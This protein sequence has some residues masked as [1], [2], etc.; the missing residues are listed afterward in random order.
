MGV[1]VTPSL[2]TLGSIP[3]AHRPMKETY[4]DVVFSGQN[5]FLVWD[6]M[7][8]GAD[9]TNFYIVTS[10]VTPAGVVLDTPVVLSPP[11]GLTD[12]NNTRIEF[13][14]NRCLAVWTNVSGTVFGRFV[15][16][17]GQPSGNAFT[18]LA[19]GGY[20]PDIA[21]DGTNYLVIWYNNGYDVVGQF[22]S[23]QGQLVGGQ[24]AVATGS[25]Q[26]MF[27]RVTYDGQNYLVVWRQAETTNKLICGQFVSPSGSLIGGNFAISDASTNQ[28]WYA[29]AT[30]SDQ[31][32][33]VAWDEDRSGVITDIYG[34][35]DVSVT[36]IQEQGPRTEPLERFPT[37]VRGS[38]EFF[39]NRGYLIYDATGRRAETESKISPGVYFIKNSRE[40]ASVIHKVLVV[41]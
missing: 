9:T 31:N 30:A 28:K 24:V 27:S 11:L 32:Y 29:V 38:L 17:T 25:V 10:R 35:V 20:K 7:N 6:D 8:V 39:T 34:N 21:F 5:Y 26:Q 14:G 13:D 3:I 37:V 18:V 36:A 23:P 2:D 33:L 22:V 19:S 41:D 15:D 40:G 12:M 4:P 1:R 16:S